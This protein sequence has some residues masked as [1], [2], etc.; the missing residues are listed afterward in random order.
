MCDFPYYVRPKGWTHDVPVPCGRCPPCKKRRVDSWAFRLM[1]EE[2]VSGFS[3][4]VTL[5]YDPAH[6]PISPNG[7]LTLDKD[8]F[9]SFMKRLRRIYERAWDKKCL[10]HYGVADAPKPPPLKYFMCGEYGSD[11]LRPHYHAIVFN[12]PD[13]EFFYKAWS[14]DGVPFGSI[15]VGQVTG[16]S[17]A[18]VLNYMDKKQAAPLFSGWTP[19]V[20]RDDRLPEFQFM[21][22]GL[23]RSYVSDAMRQ[24]HLADLSRNYATKDGGYKIALPRY[25]RN[26][27]YD[28][29][30]RTLQRVHAHSAAYESRI[31]DYDDYLRKYGDNPNFTYAGYL[32]SKR[33]AHVDSFNAKLKPRRL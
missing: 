22:K 26:I 24:Y 25:Y 29:S 8:A 21:S 16:N 17:C 20:G 33:V 13:T 10:E 11:N 4:F 6:V 27:I 9:S 15:D 18:Y 28:D 1:Q 12:V 3:H 5:T 7:W 30:Q 23:G 19:F 14:L 32:E 2:K 31:D